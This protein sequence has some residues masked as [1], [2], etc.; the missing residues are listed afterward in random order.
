[1]TPFQFVFVAVEANFLPED[2]S[3]SQLFI[4]VWFIGLELI[5]E[6]QN[7]NRFEQIEIFVEFPTLDVKSWDRKA[8]LM[9]ILK[10]LL[11]QKQTN[12]LTI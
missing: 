5:Q 6:R 8:N 1:M 4:K 10:K 7:K 12:R 3:Q 2:A 9:Q 11:G